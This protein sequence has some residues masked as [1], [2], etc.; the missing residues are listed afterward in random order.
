MWCI[1]TNYASTEDNL[2]MR[3][4]HYP[5]RFCLC[6]LHFK[7]VEH[8]FLTC[9][10]SK[11]IWH[12]TSTALGTTQKWQGSSVSKAWSN[13][14]QSHTG[15]KKEISPSWL[16]MALGLCIVTW[17]FKVRWLIC[18]TLATPLCRSIIPYQSMNQ[19]QKEK[20]SF[21]K[22]LINPFHGLTLTGP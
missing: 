17:F 9:P 8:L 7:D 4:I 1:L 21:Q 10:A 15:Q 12:L 19:Q 11:H 13:W 20:I 22:L 16:P 14:W 6:K 2:N 5:S 3:Y 18:P